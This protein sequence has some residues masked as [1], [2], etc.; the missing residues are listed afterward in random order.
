MRKKE[1]RTIYKDQTAKAVDLPRLV[2]LEWR[3]YMPDLTK[4]KPTGPYYDED[5]RLCETYQSQEEAIAAA[6]AVVNDSE[7]GAR[8]VAGLLLMP[9]AVVDKP[10][11]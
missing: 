8:Y 3:W 9:S 1:M 10:N 6:Q 2:R 7:L 5:F 4:P 11:S